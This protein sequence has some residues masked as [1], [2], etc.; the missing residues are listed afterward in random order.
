MMRR[1]IR[2]VP[3]LLALTSIQPAAA[4]RPAAAGRSWTEFTRRMDAYAR[5]QGIVGG[6]AMLVRDGRIVER[7]HVGSAD[8]AVG[9]PVDDRTLFHWASVTKTLT[10]IAVLQ[11]RD[12]GLLDLD[13]PIT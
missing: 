3:V 6:S 9:H 12:R 11:L 10:A 1:S 2:L 5:A 7:H 13:D 8:R 4:Q